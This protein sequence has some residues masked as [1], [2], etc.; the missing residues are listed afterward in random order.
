[1]IRCMKC[2]KLFRKEEITCPNCGRTAGTRPEKSFC[3]YPGTCIRN[4]YILGT[5]VGTG[6]TGITYSAWDEATG[7]HVAVKEYFPQ[8]YAARVSGDIVVKISSAENAEKY[9]SG[10][11][12]F[13][14]EARMTAALSSSPGIIRIYDSFE[15]NNTAY[16]VMEYLDGVS[17]NAYMNYW[18]GPVPSEE[19]LEICIPV[20]DTLTELHRRGMIHRDVTPPNIFICTDKRVKLIDFG[21]VRISD[22]QKECSRAAN[23]TFGYAPP[24]QYLSM[25]RQSSWTDT[26]SL[27]AVLYRLVTGRHPMNAHERLSDDTLISPLKLNPQ[28]D[29]RIDR[30]I[31]KGMSLSPEKRFRT[32]EELKNALLELHSPEASSQSQPQSEKKLPVEW[33]VGAAVLAAAV[34]SAA[35]GMMF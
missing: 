7:M 11:G 10:L 14:N 20:C 23:G 33:L 19:A 6:G 22:D 26:Y 25:S 28:L 13:L 35:I 3:I 4:R 2:M 31:M 18:N 16:I 12:C 5:V 9:Y 32:A 34:I 24:E 29:V 8:K 30:I 15:E 21:N 17:L 27:C 1:M